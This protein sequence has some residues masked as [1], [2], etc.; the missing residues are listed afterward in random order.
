MCSKEARGDPNW[1]PAQQTTQSETLTTS[2]LLKRGNQVNKLW[3]MMEKS[4]V[5]LIQR[6]SVLRFCV[7]SW[8]GES[9]SKIKYCLGTTVGMVERFITIHNF[10][11]LTALRWN[12][13]WIFPRIHHSAARPTS[14]KAHEKNGRTRTIPKMNYLH[15][16]VQWHH[17]RN[18]RQCEGMYC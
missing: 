8:K 2:G 1:D 18:Y 11:Q 5:S 15:V 17:L 14:P 10:G 7:K 4:S 6:L 9:E 16:D 12:S 13:R 3:S